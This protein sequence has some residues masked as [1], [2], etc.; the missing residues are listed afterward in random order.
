MCKKYVFILALL[1]IS[2][3]LP[4]C[5]GETGGASTPPSAAITGGE[6]TPTPAA[7]IG[8]APMPTP[9]AN[10]GMFDGS[11]ATGDSSL[12]EGQPQENSVVPLDGYEG[13]TRAQYEAKA[14]AAGAPLIWAEGISVSASGR[15][16]L[17]HS[18]RNCFTTFGTSVFLKNCETGDEKLVA[19]GS[20]GSCHAAAGWWIDEEDAVIQTDKDGVR[21]YQVCDPAGH[22]SKIELDGTSPTVIDLRG[23]ALIFS[24]GAGSNVATYGRVAKDG[25]ISG[26]IS[27]TP[28][29]GILMDECKI[30][31]DQ[32]YVAFKVRESY[33]TPDR[34][35]VVWDTVSNVS[36]TLPAPEIQN[37]SDIAAIDLN[38]STE[39][40]CVNFAVTI[41]GVE[42]YMPFE[43]TTA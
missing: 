41:D 30:S 28:D 31:P 19:D 4:G 14:E 15:Y 36:A 27:F 8:S 34:S 20:D 5:T 1:A 24:D 39:A 23:G 29:Q 42:R 25:S 10:G 33:E 32:R 3:S 26:S 2:L 13:M 21:T 17:F 16:A 40:L 11:W 6:P 35:I 18:N 9:T 7:D 37:A 38:W 12:F 43:W 22:L